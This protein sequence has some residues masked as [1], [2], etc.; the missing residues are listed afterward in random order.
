[1]E[2]TEFAELFADFLR[3]IAQDRRPGESPISAAIRD[4]LGQPASSLDVVSLKLAPH[5]QPNVQLALDLWA[6]RPN[7]EL[8]LIGLSG[9]GRRNRGLTL[10]ELITPIDTGLLGHGGMGLGPV[11]YVS[12]PIAVGRSLSCVDFGVVLAKDGQASIVAFISGPAPRHGQDKLVVEAVAAERAGAERFL[13]ELTELRRE[14]DVHRGQVVT[15]GN[16]HGPFHHDAAEVEFIDLPRV[17]RDDVVLPDGTLDL[18]EEQTI[19]M[20]Q[21]APSLLAGGRHLK[22]GL[23]LFGPRG[24]GKTHT[25]TYLMGAM[26]DRT[27][28]VLSGQGFGAIAPAAEMARSLAPSMLILEDV[29]LIA[30]ER[31]MGPSGTNP[32]LFQLL[33]EMDGVGADDDV[34]FALTTNRVDLLEPALAARPGRI[35]LA[36]E[37]PLPDA[38]GRRRLWQ[39]YATGLIVDAVDVDA[40]VDRTEGVTASFISELLRRGALYAADT[41]GNVPVL[42]QSVVDRA[43][44]DMLERGGA[45]GRR[46][47]GGEPADVAPHGHPSA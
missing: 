38:D 23:L 13:A 27:S 6:D 4:H 37:I 21:R 45:L 42:T 47:L 9:Q 19:G 7:R 26:P 46:L 31:G 35:D 14:H 5:E 10:G 40:V 22:R 36:I 28:I 2:R 25:L 30:Q 20:A 41:S 8:E 29:D 16:P 32:L 24:T 34:I 39:A 17:V 33:N 43:L 1:M 18:I 11:D 15:L 44:T 12:R 3:G